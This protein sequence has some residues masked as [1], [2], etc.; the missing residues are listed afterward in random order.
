LLTIAAIVAACGMLVG[1]WFA[2][3]RGE[4]ADVGAFGMLTSIATA[5]HALASRD[6]FLRWLAA[7]NCVIVCCTIGFVSIMVVQSSNLK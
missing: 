7:A 6:R 1:R 4:L 2:F 3:S 5:W